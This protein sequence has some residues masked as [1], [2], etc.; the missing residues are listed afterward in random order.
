[1]DAFGIAKSAEIPYNLMKAMFG[2]IKEAAKT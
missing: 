1:M 2:K